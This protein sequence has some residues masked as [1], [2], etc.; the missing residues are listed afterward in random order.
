M[1]FFTDYTPGQ[2]VSF[3]TTFGINTLSDIKTVDSKMQLKMVEAVTAKKDTAE[4]VEILNKMVETVTAKKDTAETVEVLNDARKNIK[5]EQDAEKSTDDNAE[6]GLK[7]NPNVYI[8]NQF[9]VNNFIDQVL[10]DLT[11]AKI[12]TYVR[13]AIM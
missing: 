3:T 8:P 5:I 9:Q 12:C 1:G 7:N 11:R 10:S 6:E 4:T 13:S 2:F